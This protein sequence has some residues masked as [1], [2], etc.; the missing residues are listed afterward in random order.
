FMTLA[1]IHVIDLGQVVPAARG[2]TLAV[3]AEGDL[4]NAG[5]VV[6]LDGEAKR[7]G[8]I[9]IPHGGQLV[10][11]TGNEKLAVG[12]VG[13]GAAALGGRGLGL[14]QTVG[15]VMDKNLSAIRGGGEV[16]AIGAE[17]EGGN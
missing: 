15:Q 5:G 8:C 2:E 4:I 12:T 16:L 11:A 6:G 10:V 14:R 3:G 7:C 9:R 17:G 13:Q 1:A